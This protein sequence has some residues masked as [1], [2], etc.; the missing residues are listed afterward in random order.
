MDDRYDVIIIGG[1]I[2][3]SSIARDS[4]LRG[5]K[6][7]LVERSD[8]ASGASSKTSKLVHGGLRY[9]EK[10]QIGLV[11]ESLRE[12]NRLLSSAPHLVTPRPFL[13]PIFRHS[14]WPMWVSEIGMLLYDYLDK[15]GTLPRHERLSLE[16]ALKH[17][18]FLR[19][20]GW[21]GSHLFYDATMQDS[22]LVIENVLS[23]AAAGAHP[24]NYTAVT[25]LV[26]EDR[27][28]RGVRCLSERRRINKTVQAP[29]V[30]NATGAWANETIRYDNPAASAL[31][32]PTK[33][34][35]IIV[36]A[37]PTDVAVVLTAAKDQRVF[38]AIP[39]GD[40]SI[41]G[42]T[43]TDYTG[44]LDD[45]RAE[46]EDISYLLDAINGYIKPPH[47]LRD[48]VVSAYAG[49]RPL[50]LSHRRAPSSV[51]RSERII[52]TSSG[53]I[54]VVGGKFTTARAMAEKATD[55]IVKRL[56]VETTPCQTRSTP[57]FG[58]GHHDLT[59]AVA[60]DHGIA[61]RQMN[62]LANTYGSAYPTV[63]EVIDSTPNGTE[64]LCPHHPHLIGEVAYAIQHEYAMSLEDWF[65]R[66]TEIGYSPCRGCSGI[67]LA[68]RSFADAYDWD[69]HHT[70]QEVD[71]YVHA[72]R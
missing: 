2:C 50:A 42:T 44:S 63:L 67:A 8:F 58:G 70:Q 69:E 5:L 20:E 6:V 61:R 48:D 60:A 4:A 1:G 35:H 52:T 29:V 64:P 23:A 39:W 10:L 30:V 33:G 45:V 41:I 32:R 3:G 18:P 38:F 51:S 21:R 15:G 59:D 13:L 24:Y 53:M 37:L 34:V 27:G 55:A 65:F 71:S 36:P 31:V 57:L 56:D 49:L 40:W 9:L 22:R 14:R 19:G 66:R 68:A 54:C 7:L 25:G 62:H 46:E 16:A 26:K 47:L 72:A 28:V 11:R 12:R 43:D 17:A